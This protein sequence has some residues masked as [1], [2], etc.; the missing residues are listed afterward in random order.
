VNRYFRHSAATVTRRE[1]VIA[2]TATLAYALGLAPRRAFADAEKSGYVEV[3]T[4][5]GRVRGLKMDGLSTFKGIPYGGS[6][7]G[8]N[9]FKA[10]PPLQRWAGVRDAISLARPQSNHPCGLLRN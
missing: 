3:H 2:G 9:R 1:F 7:S 4:T 5:L 10:A 6:V 8:V